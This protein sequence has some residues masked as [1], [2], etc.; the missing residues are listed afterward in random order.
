MGEGS[1][2]TRWAWARCLERSQAMRWAVTWMARASIRERSE[3][4]R[5][6]R[7]ASTWV[8]VD[9]VAAMDRPCIEALRC[10]CLFLEAS[11]PSFQVGIVRT[12]T[13]SR[14]RIDTL[15]VIQ[16]RLYL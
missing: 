12:F 8:A 5:A 3:G 7:R 16:S 1:Q 4:S 2:A 14:R 6:M 11:L 13:S 9:M 10:D 15:P